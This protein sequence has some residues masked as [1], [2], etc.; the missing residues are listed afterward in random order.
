MFFFL[1]PFRCGSG[2]SGRLNGWIKVV[3][4][5]LAGL[6]FWVGVRV[7]VRVGD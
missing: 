6:G 7:R 4:A 2:S 1:L 3:V 5:A